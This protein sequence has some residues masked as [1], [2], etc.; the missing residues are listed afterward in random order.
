MKAT[1]YTLTS[2][3]ASGMCTQVFTTR[4]DLR[5]AIIETVSATQ[6]ETENSEI[7]KSLEACEMDSDQWEELMQQW[8]DSEEFSSNYYAW[9]S[10][11]ITLPETPP[12]SATD[13]PRAPAQ[14]P[15]RWIM[16][17][18]VVSTAHVT[19]EDMESARHAWT[20]VLAQKLQDNTGSIVFWSPEETDFDS[21]FP[22]E[23][24]SEAFRHLCRHFAALGYTALRL[25]CDGDEIAGL[26]VFDW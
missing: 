2:D 6:D 20:G 19:R 15:E 24:F 12:A 3:D 1:V 22:A 26:P 4:E 14:H 25:D 10:H 5:R 7:A 18:P 21:R 13:Y 17:L 9:S 8:R 16:H 23:E 11:E